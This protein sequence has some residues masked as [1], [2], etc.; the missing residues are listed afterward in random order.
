[1]HTHNYFLRSTVKREIV[2]PTIEKQPIVVSIKKRSKKNKRTP[3]R[4]TCNKDIKKR[5]KTS[6]YIKSLSERREYSTYLFNNNKLSDEYYT[7]PDTWKR[8]IECKNLKNKTVFEPFYGDGSAVKMLKK[9]VNIKGKKDA[10]FW[11]IINAPEY[12]NLFIMSNPPF[13]FKW[14]VINTLI[15]QG[16]SFAFILTWQCFYGKIN[17]DGTR[18]KNNLQRCQELFGGNYEV[19]KLTAKEQQF[20]NPTQNKMVKIGCSILHWTF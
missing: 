3:K 5:R 6:D 20:Y 11:D 10:N 1:M 8:F 13:S 4:N 18:D 2:A 14:Q 19:F 15:E 16:R 12:K 7:R 17:K 9:Y